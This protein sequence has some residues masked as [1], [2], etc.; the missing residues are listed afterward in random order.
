[1]INHK[2]AKVHEGKIPASENLPRILARRRVL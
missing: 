1:M 2:G